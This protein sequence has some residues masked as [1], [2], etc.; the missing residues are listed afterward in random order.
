MAHTEISKI[1]ASKHYIVA[2]GASAGGLEAIHQFFDF[3]PVNGQF[4]FVI[5][6]HLSS[7]YKSLLVEL[8]SKHTEMKVFEAKH[9]AHVEKD[10]VY[11]I[12]N[13][14]A[15]KIKS[16]R[17]QLI[18]KK[19][20]RSP[21]TAIDIFLKSLAEDQGNQ[22]IAVILSGT[23]TD[24]T[25][26]IEAIQN[27]GGIVLVQEPESAKFNGMPNSAI[28]AGYADYILSPERMP[29]AIINFA[30]EKD[31][32]KFWKDKIDEDHLP[33][34]F[35]LLEKNC[36]YD[37]HNY[38]TPTITRRILRRMNQ[39]D[40]KS[41]G[42]YL[43]ILRSSPD[44][45]K[46]L[47]KEFLIGVTKFFRDDA[48][49][50]IF[51]AKVLP[52][53]LK[54]KDD[55]DIIKIWVTA[56]ST[57]QE[58]YSI[59]IMVNEA[60]RNSKKNIQVKIFATDIDLDAIEQ[61]SKGIFPASV[62]NE[63]DSTLLNRYFVNE[64]RQYQISQVIRKQIVFA[65]HN[66]LKDPPFIN[67]DVISCRNML[68]Y[69]NHLLQR[70][71]FSTF[72]YSLNLGGFLFLGPSET[73]AS[74]APSLEEVDG[75][76]KIFRKISN[77]RVYEP[78]VYET[79]SNQLKSTR[80][81]ITPSKESVSAKELA[82]DFKKLLT[83]E[84]NFAAV[85]VDGNYE[86][87]E[88]IGD[89]RKY[90]SLPQKIV[91]LNVL[92]MV[93]T[94]ISIALNA[95]L[96]KATKEKEKV[97]L[98]HVRLNSEEDRTIN[99]YVKPS[100]GTSGYTMIVFGESPELM[101]SKTAANPLHYPGGS[102]DAFVLELEEELKE[103]RLNLQMAVESLETTNEELQSSNEELLSANEEL[104]SS[105]EE[106]QSLNEELHTLNT[107]HQLKIK[108]LIE[109]NDDLNNYFR[110][111]D[112]GQIF[113]DHAM[114]IRKFNPAAVKL[115]NLIDSDLGRPI[116][117]ISTNLKDTHLLHDMKV[118]M[119]SGSPVEKEVYL[120]NGK[121]S[122]MRILPYEK[123][124]KTTDGLVITFYDITA[125]SELNNI[126]SGVFRS[127]S[128]VI[129]AFKTIIGNNGKPADLMWV[130]ANESSD[131]FFNR[132][133]GDYLQK[134]VSHEWP[135]AVQKGMLQKWLAVTLTGASYQEEIQ[136][137][138]Q[139][140]ER[141]FKIVASKMD[142]GLVVTMM[143]INEQKNIENILRKNFQELVRTKE[144]LKN[145]NAS[146][147]DKILER[148]AALTES[149]ERFRLIANATSD[150]VWDWNLVNNSVWWS[151]SLYL[152]F[153]FKKEEVQHIS[154]FWFQNIH[155][156]D[157]D[158]V[159]E[160]I[161]NA[162][163]T[164]AT[165]WSD[166]Y[167]FRKVDGTYA[168][169]LDKGSVITDEAGVP[170]RMVGSMA[171]I[172]ENEN[173]GKQLEER[174]S[175]LQSLIQEFEFVT[176]F[177]PQMVWSTKPDGYHDFFNK[178]WYDY[179][180]LNYEQTKDKGWAFILHPEDKERT[181]A[182]WNH[183]LQ[184]GDTYEIE[185]RMRRH[186]GFYRW[187]LARALPMRDDKGKIIKWFGTCTD[188]HDQKIMA[189]VLEQKVVE[190]TLELQQTNAE[191]EASNSELLQFASVASHDLKEPLRKIHMFSNIIKDRFGNQLDGAESYLDRIITSSARMTRLINDLLVYSRLSVTALF[192]RISLSVIIEEVLMDLE[193]SIAE[194]GA[195]V[196]VTE[197]PVLDMV[198][199][200]MRQVFQNLISNAL[201][202]SQPDKPP[203]IKIT[204]ELVDNP[205]SSAMTSPNCRI[206]V[207]DNGI[208]F[209]PKYAHKI[210]TIFQRLHSTEKFE[211]TGIGLAITKKIIERHNGEIEVHSVE[212]EG[213]RFIISLPVE[214][215]GAVEHVVGSANS[216][217]LGG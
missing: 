211:G 180:G 83:E 56:C 138:T 13:D 6:Q 34:I 209:D 176:D 173:K 11:V 65:R 143:D 90:L 152:L 140:E 103:T 214:Q 62:V 191:L 192:E 22:A 84:M 127:S 112:I 46:I 10:S 125:L 106:L 207:Q 188:I 37:F 210:F 158:R 153:G 147:E 132:Q 187:F 71:V 21:N 38:K 77:E 170:Y 33:E 163:N 68:I 3:M 44:E 145:V 213:T 23:G 35:R 29:E 66:I 206:V 126:L 178:G 121:K 96:R 161:H 57:G 63:I 25:R 166:Q 81:T 74:I 195:T 93:S 169:I 59:A 61:A 26:G 164:N 92:K 154:D 175:E 120:G 167:R 146:L 193:L 134:I 58:A 43:D 105:N 199:G 18:E 208:G 94:E 1:P 52:E 102:S 42:E 216:I 72:Q 168:V 133:G 190:R 85:Y 7:D 198:P 131:Y 97:V 49:F 115:I 160:S 9:D 19:I 55:G 15:L 5:I 186:D 75:K 110:S 48:A 104:Q 32:Q 89:F 142:E 109:L 194:K 45:C 155:D 39:L 79:P 122:L 95:A 99:I 200:Q 116:E 113:V 159:F 197:L 30:K 119:K 67:N 150:V 177:M 16:G 151:E 40:K 184:T 135:Q 148:T 182:V 202:F 4:S 8:I 185:Y 91:T 201:K 215:N 179:T 137:T 27:H 87:K 108:E 123:Q 80:A 41:F 36:S 98:S 64:G 130:A 100:E 149:E 171:D 31:G 69:M 2:I 172:T 204:A 88:A 86:I 174:N 17:L 82:E 189:D 162:I 165:S 183:C 107:E 181:W 212:G 118:V 47:G 136:L 28:A 14:K 114:R 54:G 205:G 139:G 128:N 60:L 24:G 101:V 141:W 217:V 51:S 70:K 73:P 196:E 20:D 144:T 111:S 78:A 50:E 76:W 129:M 12:P 157:R 117:H 124:D 203:Y 156:D 53:I